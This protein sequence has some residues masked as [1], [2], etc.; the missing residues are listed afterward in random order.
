MAAS[1]MPAPRHPMT[2]DEVWWFVSFADHLAEG[3]T[4]PD[5]CR[6]ATRIVYGEGEHGDALPIDFAVDAYELAAGREVFGR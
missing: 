4:T 1:V 2:R 3:F 6:Y 5:A